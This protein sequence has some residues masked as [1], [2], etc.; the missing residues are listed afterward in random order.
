M[1]YHN[2][3][4]AHS[5]FYWW[6][7]LATTPYFD[8]TFFYKFEFMW[9]ILETWAHKLSLI[10]STYGGTMSFYNIYSFIK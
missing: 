6:L 10:W 8:Q 4:E 3:Y 1:K 2:L 9:L 5:F 7:T